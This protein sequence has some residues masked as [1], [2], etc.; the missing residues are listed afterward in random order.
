[1]VL[2][3]AIRKGEY[4]DSVL[5]MR[6][7]QELKKIKGVRD[8]AVLI[9]T[10]SNKALL[11]EAGLFTEEIGFATSN[12]VVVV[13]DAENED[14]VREAIASVDKLLKAGYE[15][16]EESY[17]TLDAALRAMP[18]ANL[19]VIS[20]PGDF[21]GW[22]ARKALERG[23]NVFL[24]SSGISVEEEVELKKK[25]VEKG[26]LM[27]GP[28]CGTA[29]IDGVGLG[30]ANVVERGT[31]GTVAAAG[32]GIQEV[33]SLITRLGSGISQAIGTGG[34]D[35]R[36]EVGGIMML[37]GLELLS[38]DPETK[39]IVVISKPP[40]P[41]VEKKIL[42]FISGC[43]KPVVVDFIGGD[44][45]E[46]KR[47][48]A[49][50]AFTLEDAASRAVALVK[51]LDPSTYKPFELPR[52][53][54]ENMARKEFERLSEEQ[55]YVR[56]LFS[57]GTLC[58]EAM[59]LLSKLIGDVHSNIPLRPEL[60]LKNSLTSVVHTCIDMGTE[61]FVTGRPHPM[62]DLTPRISRLLKEARDPEVAVI[63]FDLVLGYGANQDP[64]GVLS[65]AIKKAKEFANAQGRYLAVVASVC[66][67]E[68]D[69][70]NFHKQRKNLEDAGVVV[71]PSNAQAARMAALIASRGEIAGFW[72]G[73]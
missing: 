30:F 72:E 52:V 20:V 49:I 48:G 24:F 31:I 54:M 1:M 63:L 53:E 23:L 64:A 36:K 15:M 41:E 18:D 57:G 46:V 73:N 11:R 13:V 25:A 50:P 65:P 68:R 9:A 5:L 34:R 7:S 40:D 69:P 70:Q 61:E 59:I 29:I 17:P 71:M 10:D 38:K 43:E 6:I 62:I 66:G 42:H 60:R 2:G 19:V 28:D 12:D 26:L 14:I 39:V 27:M 22:E 55:K 44:L 45:E 35:L 37:K 4:Y 58:Y 67:T 16:V 21:A 33:T 32:T 47:A 8:A 3:S 51:N 56:G